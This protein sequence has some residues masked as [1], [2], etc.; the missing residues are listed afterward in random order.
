[1]ADQYIT[2][3][4]TATQLTDTDALL[5]N[6]SGIARM[7]TGELL[8]SFVDRNVMNI[9]IVT[10][11]S[12]DP[13][14]VRSFDPDTGTL[15][16]NIPKGVGIDTIDP[17]PPTTT[18]PAAL[19][20]TYRVTLESGE[21]Y[22]VVFYDGRGIQSIAK[23]AG[24]TSSGSVDTYTIYY[25][26]NTTSQFYV[27]NGRDGAGQV[28]KVDGVSSDANLNVNLGAM[29]L[30]ASVGLAMLDGVDLNTLGAG[31]VMVNGARCTNSP[32]NG[33]Y[34][35][36]CSGNAGSKVQ[37]A[38]DTSGTHQ[39]MGRSCN[40]GTWESWHGITIGQT[41]IMSLP[42]ASWVDSGNGYFTQASPSFSIQPSSPVTSNTKIDLQPTAAQ[43]KQMFSD[44][45]IALMADNDGGTITVYA[46]GDAPTVDLSL[47][48][49]MLE[50]VQT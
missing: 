21:H 7:L 28:N 22:D 16:L 8:R 30:D 31:V 35:V 4:P 47:Q 11:E 24:D 33:F 13:A 32:Y 41:A 36:I 15:V 5:V 9:S 42:S 50:V 40:S 44:G 27:Y 3:L 43:I 48:C 23:T 49:S 20:R 12:T 46:V 6:Q 25:N 18:G 38:I 29:R 26:D 1:M 37:I 19:K 17:V 45:T 10:V 2:D 14:G 39:I 34:T